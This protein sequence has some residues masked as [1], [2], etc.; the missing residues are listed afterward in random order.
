MVRLRRRFRSFFAFLVRLARLRR[1]FRSF[2]RFGPFLRVCGVGF[3]RFA[4]R[5]VWVRLR[6]RFRSFSRFG[7]FGVFAASVSVVF[8]L[9]RACGVG[10]VFAVKRD[11]TF[12]VTAQGRHT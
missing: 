9:W 3:G 1:R 11:V 10:F 6:R 7:P 12:A 4:F 8:G 2:L 5:C